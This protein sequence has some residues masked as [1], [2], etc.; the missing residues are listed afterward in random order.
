MG[1]CEFECSGKGRSA[2]EVFRSLRD[3]A[4][5]EC[6]HGGYTGTIAEKPGF[7]IVPPPS[8]EVARECLQKMLNNLN[9]CVE[10]YRADVAEC[11]SKIA[12]PE[13]ANN[14]WDRKY[15]PENL[16]TAKKNL[17]EAQTRLDEW[18]TILRSSKP[19]PNGVIKQQ[20]TNWY[21]DKHD[22][23]KWGDAH[24]FVVRDPEAVKP[25]GQVTAAK[26]AKAKWGETAEVEIKT[27]RASKANR[28]TKTVHAYVYVV[29]EKTGW[30]SNEQ[31]PGGYRHMAASAS[32]ADANEARGKLFAE[33]G[34]YIFFGWASS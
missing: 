10:D 19:V 28:K 29:T 20:Y 5:Y 4:S 15:L 13:T 7:S 31:V 23:D 16:A 21:L 1:G 9:K 14:E 22:N 32:G 30:G 25:T 3:S 12:H 27:E 26:K 18:K 2:A 11:E 33:P 8:D 34:E 17:T 24:C 6:G